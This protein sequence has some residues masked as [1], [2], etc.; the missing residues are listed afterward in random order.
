MPLLALLCQLRLPTGV[1]KCAREASSRAILCSSG[2]GFCTDSQ[3][4]VHV[5]VKWW[6]GAVD[7]PPLDPSVRPCA[8]HLLPPA[9]LGPNV[10]S[11]ATPSPPSLICTPPPAARAAG[12]PPRLLPAAGSCC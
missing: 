10:P 9:A 5:I 1:M 8:C 6:H 4:C 12:V 2:P 7:I 3:G 11:E